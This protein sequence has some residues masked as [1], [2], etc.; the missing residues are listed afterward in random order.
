MKFETTLCTD[1]MGLWSTLKRD[2]KTTHIEV[3]T[4]EE[5]GEL[6]EY[7]ELLVY[8]DTSTWEVEVNGLIYTDAKFLEMLKLALFT[9][10]LTGQDVG[11]SEQGMQGSDYVSLDVDKQFMKVWRERNE[12]ESTLF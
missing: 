9:A 11:Y 3:S 12:T 5:E 10:G 4:W 1:G 8:F 7:G 6:P 2:V